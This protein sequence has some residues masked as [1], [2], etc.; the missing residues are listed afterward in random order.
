MFSNYQEKFTNMK[1]KPKQFTAAF[2]AQVGPVR[3]VSHCSRCDSLP[4]HDTLVNNTGLLEE[5]TETFGLVL[6]INTN[7][8][9][10][11]AMSLYM[12]F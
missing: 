6:L 9:D 7:I 5:I 12:F 2:L 4:A 3:I 11:R 8:D 1:Y 10:L